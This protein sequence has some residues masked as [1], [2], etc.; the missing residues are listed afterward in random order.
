MRDPLNDVR[1]PA[2][3]ASGAVLVGVGSYRSLPQFPCALNGISD[4]AAAVGGPGGLFA[5]ESVHTV[6][7][8]ESATEVLDRVASAVDQYTDTLLFYFAGHGMRDGDGQ[9]CLAL[10]WSLDK[11]SEAERTALPVERV[12]ALMRRAKAENRIVILDCR[13]SGRAMR[14]PSAFNVHLLTATGQNEKVRT[15]AEQR[16]TPFTGA[17]VDLLRNGVPGAG[18]WLTL[19]DLYRWIGGA[20]DDPTP[21]QRAVDG[22]AEIALGPNRAD[23]LDFARRAELAMRVGWKDPGRAA[24]LFAEL[25]VDAATRAEVQEELLYRMSAASWLGAAG[26][27]RGALARW[28]A[29]RH[30][31][32]ADAVEVE[33]NIAYWRE[34][35]G[36]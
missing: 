22:S 13:Y 23:R 34:R 5:P 9:L 30:D 2:R 7:D 28:E 1:I 19:G 29:L 10:P 12:M 18:R 4:L 6:A 17:L 31:P 33:A 21:H 8:P 16:N 32:D 15:P 25:V 3:E 11:K 36:V 14:A 27:P 26:D 24:R 20:A 35:V